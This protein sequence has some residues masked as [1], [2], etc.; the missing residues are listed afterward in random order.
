MRLISFTIG[1]CI[2]FVLGWL[3]CENQTVPQPGTA[4]TDTSTAAPDSPLPDAQPDAPEQTT[5]ER[6]VDGIIADAI[7][8]VMGQA[9]DPDAPPSAAL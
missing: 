3:M 5:G 4:S 7:D 8:S 1:G 9:A 6:I 2:G